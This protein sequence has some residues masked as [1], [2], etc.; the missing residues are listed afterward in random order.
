[1]RAAFKGAQFFPLLMRDREARNRRVPSLCTDSRLRRAVYCGGKNQAMWFMH[2]NVR[3]EGGA[4]ANPFK[5]SPPWRGRREPPHACTWRPRRHRRLYTIQ[6]A[7]SALSR[8]STEEQS[9]QILTGVGRELAGPGDKGAAGKLAGRD[10]RERDGRDDGRVREGLLRG[11]DATRG[12][13]GSAIRERAE[14]RALPRLTCTRSSGG[15][16]QCIL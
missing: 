10:G 16:L 6:G 15:E 7:M 11:D 1:M 2:Q 8:S 13:T 14:Q 12:R 3:R 9:W 4:K 5:P